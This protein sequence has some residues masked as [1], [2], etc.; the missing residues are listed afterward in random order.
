MN[1]NYEQ[2]LKIE[3]DNLINCF[4]IEIYRMRMSD[5][6]E[7]V[8]LIAMPFAGI[9]IPSIQL[10][11]LEG[12]LKER[13]I[14]I[15]TRHLYLKA[16]EIYGL[17]NYNALV[18]PPNDS[19]TAQ[20]VFSKYVFPDHWNATKEKF[21][22]FFNEKICKNPAIQSDFTFDSFVHSTD[23]FYEWVIENINWEN[24]GIIGFTLNYGQFLPSLA[25]AKKI[26]KLHPEKK[27]IFGGSRTVGKLGLKVLETFDYVDFIVSG[28]GE[29]ALC[30]LASDFKNY[31]AIPRLMYRVGKEIIWNKSDVVTDLD[32]LPLPSYD[33]FFEELNKMSDEIQQHFHLQGKIPIEIS[34]GCW[35]NKCTFCNLSVQHDT[36]HEKKVDRIVEEIAFLA[37]KYQI[38]NFQM[39]GNTLPKTTYRSLF[40]KIKELRKDFTFFV[41]TRAGRLI[42]DDYQLLKEAGFTTIQTGI[43]TFSQHYIKKMNKGTRVIDNIATL[44]LCK[45]NGIANNYN[46]I[47]NYPNEETIDFEETEKN[48]RFISQYLAPPQISSLIVEFGSAIY[49]NPS[50]FNIEE[51]DYIDIDKIMF[52]EEILKQ[53]ISFFYNFKRKQ[54][55]GKNNWEQLVETWRKKYEKLAVEGL[56]SSLLMGEVSLKFM[57]SAILR[58][59]K[60]TFLTTSKE[61]CSYPASM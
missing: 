12:Y 4:S 49:N 33:P 30:R 27:I 5:S 51:L 42:S 8:L 54:D 58:T 41:E 38:A 20:M 21:R 32:S 11:I 39:I 44:K 35:W 9:A 19:Y 61:L 60:Y 53:G 55:F 6:E 13:D 50:E 46:I 29:D 40:Q 7:N 1:F 25:I 37:D 3:V 43:E 26:K 57:T 14:N 2:N 23:V 24:Y 52:P 16:A 34:R 15:K 56:H 17:L 22:T 47:V 10:P 59:Y 18:Y 48:I 45:E 28:D 36:Y 31:E